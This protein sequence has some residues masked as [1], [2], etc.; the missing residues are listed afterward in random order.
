MTPLNPSRVCG[1]FSMTRWR[2]PALGRPLGSVYLAPASGGLT[3]P[4]IPPS[5]VRAAQRLLVAHRLASRPSV[6]VTT[7][8][9][10]GSTTALRRSSAFSL[11]HRI[12][13]RVSVRTNPMRSSFWVLSFQSGTILTTS[14]DFADL[15][16]QHAPAHL[17]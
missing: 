2:S 4:R 12:A 8:L 10:P 5:T 14:E 13:A 1:P 15:G 16:A 9:V 17:A 11:P 7:R 6:R 3:P